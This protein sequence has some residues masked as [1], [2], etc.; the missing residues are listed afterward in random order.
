M[1]WWVP[2][3][4]ALAVVLRGR[5]AGADDGLVLRASGFVRGQAEITP[6]RIRCEIPGP[7]SAVPDGTFAL[8]LLDTFGVP[9]RFFPD[10]QN[11]YG[12]PCGGW[13]RVESA[14]RAQGV[15]IE[16]VTLRYQV[17][18]SRWLRR[19]ID[20]RRGL[21][22]A[23]RGLRQ[24]RVA[25]GLRLEPPVS[26]TEEPAAPGFVPLV[27][28]VSPALL[29]CLQQALVTAPIASVPLVIM[30]RAA[31]RADSGQRLTSNAAGYTLT[32]LIGGAPLLDGPASG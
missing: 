1:R 24:A 20:V 29:S 2:P 7:S 5:A 6:E 17:R 28:M 31:G 10:P 14:L 18:G 27:P 23:C 19:T 15:T 12:N 4:M 13:L 22:L 21:P 25:L 9:T 30:A 3:I 26:D 8:G 11:P 16:S 32:L